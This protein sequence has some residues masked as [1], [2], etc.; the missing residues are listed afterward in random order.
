MADELLFEIKDK[1]ATITLNRPERR[2][3][4]TPDMFDAW[5]D[6]LKESQARDDVNVVIITGA[7]TAFCSGG[8]V[9]AMGERELNALEEKNFLWEN[10]NRLPLVLEHMDKPVIA[11]VNGPA[12]GAGMD[13]ALMCDIRFAA[14]SAKFAEAYVKVGLLSGEGA[15]WYLPRLVGL[16]KAFEMLWLGDF[17][18]A[19]EALRIGLVNAVFP[20]DELMDKVRAFA[21]RIAN[22]PSLSIRMLKRMVY[23]GM[24]MDVRTH[25]DM[26]SS[27]MSIIRKTEDYK[28]AVKAFANK[29]KP[30]FKGK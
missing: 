18:D 15:T 12:A 17:I 30:V 14:Q 24:K 1:I 10:L 8:D 25:L 27:H 13:A 5:I 21:A 11:A 7:G 9:K 16:G 28:N 23:Q 3:A 29:E 6:A 26:T 2:N 20:D 19:D 22:G 4:F